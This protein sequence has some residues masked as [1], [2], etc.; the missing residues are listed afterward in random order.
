MNNTTSVLCKL[1]TYRKEVKCIFG[2]Q[3]HFCISSQLDLMDSQD[4]GIVFGIDT[5]HTNMRLTRSMRFD[6]MF[7]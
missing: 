3:M 6:K 2:V 4:E 7:R 5:T 1:H